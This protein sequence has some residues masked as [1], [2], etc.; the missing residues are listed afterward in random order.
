MAVAR[1]SVPAGPDRSL[2][3]H[4]ARA[5]PVE[6]Q[7]F[8]DLPL[9]VHHL[10][11]DVP[12]HD[13]WCIRLAGA[14]PSLTLAQLEPILLRGMKNLPV[15]VSALFALRWGLGRLLRWDRRPAAVPSG[16]S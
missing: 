6:A 3:P 4:A 2:R 10:L 7:S 8:L 12:L 13:V 11:F 9:R 5:D 15:H 16:A 14:P 1:A